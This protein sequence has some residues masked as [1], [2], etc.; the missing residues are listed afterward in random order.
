VEPI[1]ERIVYELTLTDIHLMGLF[2][3]VERRANHELKTATRMVKDTIEFNPLLLGA[4]S[5]KNATIQVLSEIMHLALQHPQRRAVL[6]GSED[7]IA[8]LAFDL[9]I[10]DQ[11]AHENPVF[12]EPMRFGLQ[13]GLSAEEYYYQLKA[14]FPPEQI[15]QIMQGLVQ[16]DHSAWNDVSLVTQ[17]MAIFR[18]TD[19][20]KNPNRGKDPFN[21]ERLFNT[22]KEVKDNWTNILSNFVKQMISTSE[23][24][25]TDKR[26]SRRYGSPFPGKKN[27]RKGKLTIAIDSSG[28]I[29]QD[30]LDT[31]ISSVYNIAKIW[32][33]PIEFLCGDADIHDD[34]V[35]KYPDEVARI[36]LHGGGGTS[37]VP[38]FKRLEKAPPELLIFFTDLYT[39]FPDKEP[40]FPVVWA[41]HNHDTE[42]PFGRLFYMETE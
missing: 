15:E 9:A 29:D 31:F 21:L 38:F 36:K 7:K 24:M 10:F 2:A 28:S 25:P 35:I 32:Q 17:Q 39:E 6:A 4:L 33:A 40:G 19:Y 5:L 23:K 42:V 11:I 12:P 41:T 37:T 22:F 27:A 34:L 26:F 13:C 30:E 8:D 3:S 16:Q 20:I 18:L 1:E 14:K